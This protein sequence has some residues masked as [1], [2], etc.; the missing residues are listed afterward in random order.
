MAFAQHSAGRIV[1][2][3]APDPPPLPNKI[4][5]RK[6]VSAKSETLQSEP[7][8][9][10]EGIVRVEEIHFRPLNTGMAIDRGAL[11]W[12]VFILLADTHPR[13][14]PDELLWSSGQRLI[15]RVD[16]GSVFP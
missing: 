5:A 4:G 3:R 9:R 10:A 8:E 7:D 6:A 14:G 16:Y 13:P 11:V 15:A 12:S 2:K 1:W